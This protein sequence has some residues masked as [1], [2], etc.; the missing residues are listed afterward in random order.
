MFNKIGLAFSALLALG[1]SANQRV[2]CD[3]TGDVYD[4]GVTA[5]ANAKFVHHGADGSTTYTGIFKD[6]NP[7]T[8]YTWELFDAQPANDAAGTGQELFQLRTNMDG[9]AN[10]AR[11][12]VYEDGEGD[13]DDIRGKWIG[14]S[15]EGS[16]VVAYC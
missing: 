13:M 7:K 15:C 8:V 5:T 3:Y 14:I 16:G 4:T 1:A 9:K 2:R 12:V 6:A 10:L 11:Y